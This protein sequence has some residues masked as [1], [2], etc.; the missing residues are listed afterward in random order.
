MPRWA[1]SPT[2][3][4]AVLD[5]RLRLPPLLPQQRPGPVHVVAVDPVVVDAGTVL[6]VLNCARWQEGSAGGQHRSTEGC[7]VAGQRSLDARLSC[8]EAGQ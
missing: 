7:L 6:Q 2:Q 8:A 5:G 1:G 4:A 3:R